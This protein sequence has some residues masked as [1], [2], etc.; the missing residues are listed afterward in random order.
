MS[1]PVNKDRLITVLAE[2]M[3]NIEEWQSE[4]EGS[5]RKEDLAD[6]DAIY[7]ETIAELDKEYFK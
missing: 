2:F 3:Q 4:I 5:P 1:N 6:L 7:D